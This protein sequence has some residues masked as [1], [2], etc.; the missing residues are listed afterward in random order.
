[1]GRAIGTATGPDA[2]ETE[3]HVTGEI[4]MGGKQPGNGVTAKDRLYPLICVCL[5]HDPEWVYVAHQCKRCL[6]VVR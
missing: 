5:I 1:M 3:G 2:T 6:R 4:P